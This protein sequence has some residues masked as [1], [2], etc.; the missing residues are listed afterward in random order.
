MKYLAICIVL[1]SCS[2]DEFIWPDLCPNCISDIELNG[3]PWICDPYSMSLENEGNDSLITIIIYE[4][5][6]KHDSFRDVLLLSNLPY[7]VGKYTLD[8]LELNK[9][10]A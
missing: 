2:K 8:S 3:S 1:F 6:S 9:E 4:A 10:Q 7:K 5:G